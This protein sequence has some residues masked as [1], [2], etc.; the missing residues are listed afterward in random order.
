MYL[1]MQDGWTGNPMKLSRA[2]SF[3]S[4]TSWAQAM[5]AHL[6][7]GPGS[8]LKMEPASGVVNGVVITTK[9]NDFDNLEWLNKNGLG[10]GDPTGVTPIFDSDHDDTWF[11]IEMHTKLNDPGQINGLQEFWI[12]G[13]LEARRTD[14]NFVDTWTAYGINAIFFENFWNDGNSPQV[15]ERYFDNIVVST[16]PIGCLD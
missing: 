5:I 1:K 8:L 10:I 6:W 13:Q 15:Q 12:D 7:Q 3:S 11:C 16:Q 9:Y 4:P 2:T 14:M